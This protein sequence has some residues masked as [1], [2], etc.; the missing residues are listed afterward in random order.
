MLPGGNAVQ[1]TAPPAP[2]GLCCQL[3]AVSVAVRVDPLADDQ[4]VATLTYYDA[5]SVPR[6][7]EVRP[8]LADDSRPVVLRVLGSN[9]APLSSSLRCA[10]GAD[11]PTAASFVSA[12]E[13]AC[14]SP[15]SS[16]GESHTV[17]LRVSLDGHI[18]SAPEEAPFH[19]VNAAAAPSLSLLLPPLGPAAGGSVLTLSGRGFAPA[20]GRLQCTFGDGQLRATA[21]S[22]DTSERVRCVAPA[23]SG[24]DGA[25]DGT[26][27]VRVALSTAGGSPPVSSSLPFVYHDPTRPPVVSALSPAYGDLHAPPTILLHGRG[28]APVGEALR[29]ALLAEAR[30]GDSGGD[31]APSSIVWT[32]AT[33][34]T[35]S[36]IRC[37][38]PPA[39]ALPLGRARVT[40]A[41]DGGAA[42]LSGVADL[43]A[44]APRYL[45]YDA[46]LLPDAA[47][48]APSYGPVL[49]G[50]LLTVTGHNLAPTPSLACVFDELG[51]TAATL[52]ADAG[53]LHC[54]TPPSTLP[55]TA[56]LALTLDHA[57]LSSDASPWDGGLSF[58]FHDDAAPPGVSF[59]TPPFA[60][61][62]GGKALTVLGL[63]FHPAASSA[64]VFS[65]PSGGAS[66]G[67]SGGD[68][69]ATLATRATFEGSASLTCASPPVA[70]ASLGTARV[71]VYALPPA[72]DGGEEPPLSGQD[73]LDAATAA[74]AATTR[75]GGGGGDGGGGDHLSLS[76]ASAPLTF[77]DEGAPPAVRAL[78]PPLAELNAAGNLASV[79]V[80]GSNF[81]PV[82]SSLLCGLDGEESLAEI[83]T[84]LNGSA[85]RCPLPLP[86]EPQDR[87]LRVSTDGGASWSDA[88][89]VTFYEPL[90]PPTVTAADPPS[91]DVAAP[92]MPVVL[93]VHNVA[94]TAGLRCGF[95]GFGTTAGSPPHTT[96]ATFLSG[97]SV[98]C[99]PPTKWWRE[100]HVHLSHDGGKTWSEIGPKIEL[101]NT[102][103]KAVVTSLSP[104]ALPVAAS[105]GGEL[106]LRGEFFYRPP[107]LASRMACV[108]LQL[109]NT[110]V[111][112]A[113]A[114]E[115]VAAEDA[116]ENA[117][118]A[119]AAPAD[120]DARRRRLASSLRLL[121][122]RHLASDAAVTSTSPATVV[123]DRHARCA[124]PGASNPHTA[125]VAL[126][127]DGGSTAGVSA[128][129]TFYDTQAP[130]HLVAVHPPD[131]QLDLS[132]LVTLSGNNFAPA[133]SPGALLCRF[134]DAHT[135]ATFLHA[136]ALACHAPPSKAVGA[137]HVALS[138][139]SGATWTTGDA[140]VPFVYYDPSTPP[141]V[142]TVS[143]AAAPTA[144]GVLLTLRGSNFVPPDAA[145]RARAA[146][147][148]G[149][150]ERRALAAAGGG[151]RCLFYSDGSE[152][153]SSPATYLSFE[154]VQCTSP[155]VDP[156]TT[157]VTLALVAG[158][159][160][161]SG[162][163]FTFFDAQAPPSIVRLDPLGLP[164]PPPLGGSDD[165]GTPAASSPPVRVYGHGF[166]PEG[167]ACLFG[168]P[169]ATTPTAATYVN[170]GEVLCQPPPSTGT[171]ASL[172]VS[173]RRA[174]LISPPELA[175]AAPGGTLRG[176]PPALAMFTYYDAA[177][178][179]ATASVTPGAADLR[180]G[181][182]IIV[183]GTGF[184]PAGSELQCAVGGVHVPAQFLTTTQVL[185]ATPI[186][187]SH[188][189]RDGASVP[190]CVVIGTDSSSSSS[191]SC[192]ARV[193]YYDP[194]DKPVVRRL[195][196][197]MLALGSEQTTVTVT[198]ANFA[199][200]G[201]GLVC[202]FGSESEPVPATFVAG[203][204]LLCSAPHATSPRTDA[205][206]VSLD[207]GRTYSAEAPPF[208]HYDGAV[209]P[210]LSVA[211]PS[212]AGL[213][214]RTRV[215]LTGGNFAPTDGFAC[216]F[217]D[218]PASP[219]TFMSSTAA[220]CV[221][222]DAPSVRTVGLRVAL[223][224]ARWSTAPL[225]F[226]L[227]DVGHAPTVRNVS[228]AYGPLGGGTQKPGS[229]AA[230]PMLV[231]GS[232]FAPTGD[233]K[234]VCKFTPQPAA[235]VDDAEAGSAAA[236][237]AAAALPSA[238]AP[239][240]FVSVTSVRCAAPPMPL[241]CSAKVSASTDGA[242]FGPALATY[243]YYD[244]SAASRIS[245]VVP[246]YGTFS[247]PTTVTLYGSNFA[248]TKAGLH[249]RWGTLGVTRATFISSTMATA[250]AASPP[251]SQSSLSVPVE[252]SFSPAFDA[253]P[254]AERLWHTPSLFTFYSPYQPPTVNALEPAQH[255]CGD[256]GASL[257]DTRSGEKTEVS[258]S[259]TVAVRGENFA[260][261]PKLSCVFRRTGESIFDEFEH[262][263]P[264]T[265]VSSHKV[266]CPIPLVEYADDGLTLSSKM[267][268]S[269]SNDNSIYR[270]S[271]HVFTFVGN[272][273]Q[274]EFTRTMYTLVYG[275]VTVLVVLLVSL[276]V[277]WFFWRDLARC[278]RK[279][280]FKVTYQVDD[281]EPA[282]TAPPT[283][284]FKRL[285][286]VRI[287]FFGGGLTPSKDSPR[288]STGS[289]AYTR[290]EEADVPP[291]K[292]PPVA[293]AA[294]S[295]SSKRNPPRQVVLPPPPP[296][297][298]ATAAT[299][300]VA[301]LSARFASAAQPPAATAQKAK[302]QASASAATPAVAPTP[303][304][305]ATPAVAPTPAPN[306]ALLDVRGTLEVHVLGAHNLAAKSADGFSDPY[307]T[308]KLPGKKLWKSSV[309]SKTLNPVWNEVHKVEGTLGELIASPMVV[310][311]VDKD[312]LSVDENLGVI[313]LNL[314]ALLDSP[315]T[316]PSLRLDQQPLTGAEAEPDSAL[317]LRILFLPDSAASAVAEPSV[318][319]PPAKAAAKAASKPGGGGGGASKPAPPLSPSSAATM[320]R[321]GTLEVHLQSASDLMAAD[322]DGFSDPY[323]TLKMHGHKTWKSS[324]QQ[325]TLHP[326]W[327]ET[328]R[329]RGP[330]SAFLEH[331]LHIKVFDKD[332]LGMG[333]D[334][335]GSA[336]VSLAGL[337]RPTTIGRGI[338]ELTMPAIELAD[339]MSGTVALTVRFVPDLEDS[340]AFAAAPEHAAAA[341]KGGAATG[342]GAATPPA[343]PATPKPATPPV[344]GPGSSSSAAA[345]G[346]GGGSGGGRS[347][348]L[349]AAPFGILEDATRLKQRGTLEV[350]L[351]GADGLR[352]ADD[353]SGTSDP[354]VML[355]FAGQKYWKSS[356]VAPRTLSPRWDE[357]MQMEGT[358]GEFVGGPLEIKVL[359]KD[360]L[361]GGALGD[362]LG[363]C[364]AMLDALAAE[365]AGSVASID[366]E[367]V[368]LL[369]VPSGTI[370]F[371]VTWRPATAA[372]L[373]RV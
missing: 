204:R 145:A 101:Y 292:Q 130:P 171:V 18:F 56:S 367:G 235:G 108:F 184:R 284:F 178:H 179:P 329:L 76:R 350:H 50:T 202:A 261:L 146:M 232:N 14:E 16:L 72:A 24:A 276:S 107:E 49:G 15:I 237:A 52:G 198:G 10:F 181:T 160:A 259:R 281:A 263:V 334:R 272:C 41:I 62:A 168:P 330:L 253:P 273:H 247:T 66:G 270:Y 147:A 164:M 90:Q 335:L 186:G 191:S 339:A 47:S 370:S 364:D 68:H 82:G 234:L 1:C 26:L 251:E 51:V 170:S 97:T 46:S 348:S 20:P 291:P 139:N 319:E 136:M 167:L 12:T 42:L 207:G 169:E 309:Q 372:P 124:A 277:L 328:M 30:T 127:F 177:A 150:D 60:S 318:A 100:A 132:T 353:A 8:S 195:S 228:R 93:S 34:L 341:A 268:F 197:R 225:S 231:S 58:A 161:S 173:I 32:P 295:S 3:G 143:P 53:T 369:D 61:A 361:R 312:Q 4:G 154:V 320:A 265:F 250:L 115:A 28:F 304:V 92:G 7:S 88:T 31:G 174:G 83:G 134:G 365:P 211:L 6:I 104:A 373:E 230:Q 190:V 243:T 212:V 227:F 165:D 354:Y 324:T 116:A 118:D 218:L 188:W 103:Q 70:A 196:P 21:A 316:P 183:T 278:L 133:A 313:A 102:S 215:A 210:S 119:D 44:D 290:L 125:S 153:G 187:Q 91:I 109:S 356:Q 11:G 358:L 279:M 310:K 79:V 182:S 267:F 121:R 325:K 74:A 298:A 63:N 283:A 113:V 219:A 138:T 233:G 285:S 254:P 357:R 176:L 126:S 166:A 271:K 57:A 192:S 249:A 112:T 149:G 322:A 256:G 71:S 289:G 65:L 36:S 241:P 344:E 54:R 323:V 206:R 214:S 236:A 248:P 148:S 217:G 80:V 35:T 122:R 84:F 347:G 89:V 368:S 141:D 262:S 110:D 157:D 208:A 81:A 362:R 301:D 226:T 297:A 224:G 120:P 209:P 264:A 331:S 162:S 326:V 43:T 111:A 352:A 129:L 123:D 45:T 75:A 349:S 137:V 193:T 299:A 2:G 95:G 39:D 151:A 144:G 96:R 308:I 38:A 337:E 307:V 23:A 333:D 240:T 200:T 327:D 142:E 128:L 73:L 9:F 25:D 303:A 343:P 346:G 296:P 59:V 269:V 245:R 19:L 114:A 172:P 156:T 140:D 359:D 135:E 86:S 321:M 48:V 294:S 27:A 306:S 185:C 205:V 175:S 229:P 213:A 99:E 221:T 13:L 360:T 258:A 257:I 189:V 302:A 199:P 336:R 305:A 280:G 37:A 317:S 94:P 33:Y 163:A 67:A 216:R 260:P 340:G 98:R 201:A 238:T 117:A 314:D 180:G 40:A 345:A 55:V 242:S 255:Q 315:H 64:C 222:P 252:V 203:D 311:V 158:E 159:L 366:F 155:A 351:K 87:S 371:A 194:S 106:L 246:P 69:V 287:N 152:A 131:G 363:R 244:P 286:S 239:A 355:R 29:C 220:V 77:Y 85:V 332:F 275:L 338:G 288:E 300:G 223:D 293:A 342:K 274:N 17:D 266:E 282:E 78:V 105:E 5:S 22:F